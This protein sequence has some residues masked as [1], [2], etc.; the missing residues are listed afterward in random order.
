MQPKS[1]FIKPAAYAKLRN[2]NKS[3][4]SR[5]IKSGQIPVNAEGMVDPVAADRARE[6]NLDPSKRLGAEI[7]KRNPA[8]RSGDRKAAATSGAAIADGD[9]IHQA[10]LDVLVEI[11]APSEVLGFALACL[12][13]GC[14]RELACA[15]AG[16]YSAWPALALSDMEPEDLDV[17]AE[18]SPDEWRRAL[19][20][21]DAEEADALCDAA[22]MNRGDMAGAEQPGVEG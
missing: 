8:L 3:T 1:K 14:S 4:V 21:F 22:L 19:G 5:Q 9:G 6:R 20:G 7:R 16:L 2:L 10:R 13:L 12:H 11:A 15:L 18:P 17:I